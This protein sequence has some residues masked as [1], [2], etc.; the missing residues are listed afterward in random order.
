M[1][2]EHAVGMASSGVGERALCHLFTQSQPTCAETVEPAGEPL[3]FAIKPLRCFVKLFEE[4]AQQ[5]V[6][7]HEPIELVTMHC[8]VSLAAVLPHITFVDRHTHQVRHHFR[9][10]VVVIPFHPH[11][12][13]ALPGVGEPS[14]AGKEVPVLAFEPT[15]VEVREDVAEQDEL[16]EVHLLEQLRSVVGAADIRAEMQV[17]EN[18]CVA[19]M[20]HASAECTHYVALR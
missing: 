4:A 19:G 16:T 1:P 13:P 17:R 11:N 20:H 10:T 8:Y 2:A 9:Q 15:E 14:D 5:N 12:P 7:V 18:Q 3:L 6:L